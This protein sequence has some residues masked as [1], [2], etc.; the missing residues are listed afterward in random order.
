VHGLADVGETM[1][2]EI[3][4]IIDAFVSRLRREEVAPAATRLRFS[5]I[6]DHVATLLADVAESLIVLEDSGGHPTPLM[7]DAAEIQRLIAERHGAQRARLGWNEA[8]LERECEILSEEVE[9]ALRH[10]LGEAGDR[11]NEAIAIIR[12]Q[13]DE[14][15]EVGIRALKSARSAES[16]SS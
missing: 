5:Q 7:Q 2:R 10:R 15:T 6:A 14:A 4:P 11:L 8:T 1:L 3:E 16:G 12:R 9:R 13:L